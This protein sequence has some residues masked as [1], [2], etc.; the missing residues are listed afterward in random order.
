MSEAHHEQQVGFPEE[1]SSFR[2]EW[3]GTHR[4]GGENVGISVFTKRGVTVACTEDGKKR[5]GQSRDDE[6]ARSAEGKGS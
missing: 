2:L 1:G 4:E 3:A 5:D 6:E